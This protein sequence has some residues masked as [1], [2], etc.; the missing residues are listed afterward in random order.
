MAKDTAIVPE[1]LGKL[2]K[3]ELIQLVRDLELDIVFIENDIL[4]A[5]SFEKEFKLAL[6]CGS[7]EDSMDGS[8]PL[9]APEGWFIKPY[10]RIKLS[11]ALGDIK[12][13]KVE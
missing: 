6:N 11:K 4:R 1:N 5:G 12:K 3:K 9:D 8:A 13:E 2:T 7:I 10:A